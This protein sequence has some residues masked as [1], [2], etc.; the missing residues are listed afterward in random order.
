MMTTNSKPGVG[1]GA[2]KELMASIFKH[3]QEVER[4][5]WKGVRLYTVKAHLQGQTSSTKSVPPKTPQ[6]APLTEDL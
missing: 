1:V 6:T 3:K 2:G 5:S 4:A